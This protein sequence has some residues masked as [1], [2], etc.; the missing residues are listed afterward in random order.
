MVQQRMARQSQ[1]QQIQH[2]QLPNNSTKLS[3]SKAVSQS[4]RALLALTAALFLAGCA[5]TVP[6]K[7]DYIGVLPQGSFQRGW[8]V[9]LDLKKGDFVTRV[10]VRDKLVYIYTFSKRVTAFDRK[11]GKLQFSMV[12]KSPID[13]LLPLVELQGMIVFPNATALEL[14]DSKGDFIK[15]VALSSPLRSDAA[16]EGTTV[17][18]GSAG[19]RG[20]LVEALDL[21]RAYDVQ[22][23]RYSTTDS[24]AVTAGPAVSNGIEYSGSNGGEV[25]A[26][27]VSTRAQLW[28]TEHNNFLAAGPIVADLQLDDSGLYIASQDTKLYCLNKST[29]KLKWQYFAGYP[30]VD[31]P[32]ITSDSVY[33]YVPGKGLV[34]LDKNTGSYDRSPRWINPTATQ[35]LSQDEKYTYVAEPS[36]DP[37]YPTVK[38]FAIVA[39]NKQTGEKE[40]ES[41]HK[42]FTVFGINRKDST[43]YA[44]RANG[45]AMAIIPVLKAGEIGVLQ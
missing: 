43:I 40:F 35:F 20:G 33:Q 1:I 5:K 29:G 13:S 41:D 36:T 7:P 38:T 44:S 12:V 4:R 6:P 2:I 15:E 24:T 25:D 34:A 31:S 17:F 45:N 16:G 28:E 22:R 37:A 21:T 9:N 27:S 26:V 18:F 14:F 3:H 32:V 19:P 23:W 42:D 11:S 10:D 30:L 8:P 39:L